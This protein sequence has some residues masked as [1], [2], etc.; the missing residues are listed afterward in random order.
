[1]LRGSTRVGRQRTNLIC[2]L[3]WGQA[4]TYYGN[5][6]AQRYTSTP[7]TSTYCPALL[8]EVLGPNFRVSALYWLDKVC[9]V[10]P[11]PHHTR[12]LPTTTHPPAQQNSQ[13]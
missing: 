1:M 12:L 9:M 3:D 4:A 13:L 8:L 5:A 10:R 2:L 11:P 6:W 7:F